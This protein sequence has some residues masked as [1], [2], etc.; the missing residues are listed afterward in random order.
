MVD[1]DRKG[2][3]HRDKRGVR[4][5]EWWIRIGWDWIVGVREE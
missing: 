3:D 5:R 4:E 1:R 2:L